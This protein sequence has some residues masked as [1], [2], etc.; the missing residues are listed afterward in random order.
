MNILTQLRHDSFVVL[1]SLD[2]S[3][4]IR[5]L[6][7]SGSIARKLTDRFVIGPQQLSQ[8]LER[9]DVDEILLPVEIA[10]QRGTLD[11]FSLS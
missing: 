5:G 7:S 10:L 11:Q 8:T 3:R 2:C 1:N 6:V 4:S 9:V